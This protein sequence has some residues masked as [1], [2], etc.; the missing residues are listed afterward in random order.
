M[1]HDTVNYETKYEI[2]KE[3]SV[4][5]WAFNMKVQSAVEII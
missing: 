1:L 5:S 2:V 3:T 4:D